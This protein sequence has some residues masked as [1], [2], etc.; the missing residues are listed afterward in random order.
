MKDIDRIKSTDKNTSATAGKVYWSPQKSLWLF[1]HT[2]VAIVGGYYT[3]SLSALSIFIVFTALSLCLGHSLGM[4]RKL[5]HN[6][7]SCPKWLEYIFVHLGVLVGMAGPKGMI[8]THDLRDWAQRQAKCHDYLRHGK[9]FF[10]DGWWQLHC[11]LKLEHPP[12]FHLEDEIENDVLYSIMERTWMLQQLPWALLLFFTGGL[13]WLVWGI[14]MRVAVSVTGH[15]LVGYFAHNRGP[16][17]WHVEGAAVQGHNV[18]L[19]AFLTMGESWHNNHHAYPGSAVLGLYKN[20][21]DPGWW[22]LKLL[23]KCGLA[24]NFKLPHDLERR[25]ELKSLSNNY[26]FRSPDDQCPILARVSM[27]NY[28]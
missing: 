13:A 14:S 8:Y 26:D 10:H 23:N 19:M 6:S 22:V 16:R 3:F 7:Y 27:K 21:P 28:R 1:F 18:P 25:P 2:A 5:I 17:D 12:E 9:G 20:Q 15:W 11:D 24:G 4:H